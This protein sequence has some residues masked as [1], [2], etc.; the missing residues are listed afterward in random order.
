MWSSNTFVILPA[1]AMEDIL[2]HHQAKQ[3]SQFVE[4]FQILKQW[5]EEQKEKLL[6]EQQQRMEML[7]SQQERLQ[8]A[9]AAQ[10]SKQ[11][12]S[13]FRNQFCFLKEET[14][15]SFR[16]RA[17]YAKQSL[18]FVGVIRDY[19]RIKCGFQETS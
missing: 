12:G 13:K 6:Q 2:E 3:Q 17:K 8:R 9:L 10:R 1:N 18:Q 14:S 7:L 11:W 15:E 5:Q 16:D 19:G 4:K